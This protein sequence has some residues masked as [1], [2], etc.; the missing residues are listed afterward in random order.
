LVNHTPLTHR[1]PIIQRSDQYVG[2]SYLCPAPTFRISDNVHEEH[3]LILRP[4]NKILIDPF[5]CVVLCVRPPNLNVIGEHLRQNLLQWFTPTSTARDITK[6][7]NGWD[8]NTNF[9]WKCDSKY[10]IP[11]WQPIDCILAAWPLPAHEDF[12]P[13]KITKSSTT[14]YRICQRQPS[15]LFCARAWMQGG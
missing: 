7:W 14:T 3:F 13:L 5:V 2:P 8:S 12:E 6:K 1:F 10:S 15:P 9:K 4:M 11:D